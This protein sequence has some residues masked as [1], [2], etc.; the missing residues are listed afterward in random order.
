MMKAINF[1]TILLITILNLNL[2][3]CNQ[4]AVKQEDPETVTTTENND[5]D[6]SEIRNRADQAYQNDDLEASAKDYELLIKRVPEEPL[7]WF[8]LANIYVRTNRPQLAVG[9]YR[10]AVIRD[11]KFAKAWY[12]LSI[13][14]LKQTAYSL[15][16]MLT[17]TDQD[18]P[19]HKKASSMLEGIETII[20][21]D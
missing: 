11:P 16:E 7:H 5:V 8:R 14:Q 18:D 6:L 12:N 17:Y 10:E 2:S 1:K 4:P 19:L 20:T 15:G 9:L 3:A 21:S 13:V